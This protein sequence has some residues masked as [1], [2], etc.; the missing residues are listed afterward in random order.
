MSS[1]ILVFYWEKKIKARTAANPERRPR[2]RKIA[3]RQQVTGGDTA[4]S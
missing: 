4:S 1:S 2:L 3:T